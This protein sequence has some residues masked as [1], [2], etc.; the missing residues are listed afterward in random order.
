MLNSYYCQTSLLSKKQTPGSPYLKKFHALKIASGDLT[1][2]PEM[3][4]FLH[5]AAVS[6]MIVYPRMV[7]S[8]LDIFD[9]FIVQIKSKK[10][11]VK[12]YIIQSRKTEEDIR[13]TWS[14]W[15]TSCSSESAKR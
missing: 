4:L 10:K 5:L 14:C 2:A 9:N 12:Q 8:R 15:T 1:D 3:A 6:Y 7:N 11:K 13:L